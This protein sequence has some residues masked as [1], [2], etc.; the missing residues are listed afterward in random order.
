MGSVKLA[1]AITWAASEP[2]IFK[3]INKIGCHHISLVLVGSH[4]GYPGS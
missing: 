3:A 1:Y 2:L 4:L